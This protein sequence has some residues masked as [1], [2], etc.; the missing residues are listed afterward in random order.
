MATDAAPTRTETI[1][2]ADGG[3]FDGALF[4]PAGGSGPGVL[5]LQEIFGVGPFIRSKGVDLAALGYVALAPDVFWRTERG[6]EHGH[7]ADGMEAAFGSATRW[8]EEV[9]DATKTSDLLAA[10][11]HL[12]NLPEVDGKVA[13]MG[14]C[15]G[16]RLAYEVAAAGAPDTCVSYY[17]SRIHERLDETAA[18]VT[19]PVLFH[20]G[21]ADPYIPS[22]QVDAVEAAFS[23]RSDVEVHRHEG[24]G[25]AFENFEA[26][27]FWNEAAA[28]WSWARTTEWLA[29]HLRQ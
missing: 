5:L 20:Y 6:V 18:E 13:V 15:L 10:L 14:Y 8:S 9:D 7:D 11:D 28:E 17:G 21:A 29:E 22:E 27:Q 26:P 24:A 12:R 3:T 1:H 2:A 25:H 16:G 4:V 19:C 23:G